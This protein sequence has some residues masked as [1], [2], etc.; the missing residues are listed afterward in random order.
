MSY[1][2]ELTIVKEHMNFSLGLLLQPSF[3]K[4]VDWENLER[5]NVLLPDMTFE[6]SAVCNFVI[7]TALKLQ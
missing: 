6:S 2:D 4:V 1:T 3:K 7:L 5:E